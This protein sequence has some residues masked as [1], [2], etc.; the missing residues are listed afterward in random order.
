MVGQA[1]VEGGFHIGEQILTGAAQAR[2]Q[3]HE[4]A[5]IEIGATGDDADS[6]HAGQE[7]PIIQGELDHG[8]GE[9]GHDL[10]D[11]LAEVNI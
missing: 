10:G 11:G 2:E 5:D 7:E 1:H 8:P 3:G 6:G 9:R 4:D